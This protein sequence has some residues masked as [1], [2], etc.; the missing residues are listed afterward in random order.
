MPK[1]CCSGGAGEQQAHALVS[2]KERHGAD[3]SHATTSATVHS[4]LNNV[5][6]A[7]R[8]VVQQPQVWRGGCT[9]QRLHE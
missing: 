7:G 9:L 4:I 6:P 3:G 8:V 5:V 1:C 2:A